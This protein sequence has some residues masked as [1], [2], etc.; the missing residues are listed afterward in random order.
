MHGLY[1]KIVQNSR[2]KFLQKRTN[3]ERY[4]IERWCEDIDERIKKDADTEFLDLGRRR[5]V[6]TQTID[7]SKRRFLQ[8]QFAKTPKVAK[9]IESELKIKENRPRSAAFSAKSTTG[10][11]IEMKQALTD[12]REKIQIN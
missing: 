4:T 8:S 1:P 10:S 3:T 5:L 11:E 12:F 7:N 2:D 6:A 9:I